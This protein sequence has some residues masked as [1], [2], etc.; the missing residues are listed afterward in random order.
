MIFRK[1]RNSE[2]YFPLPNCIFNL[3]LSAGEI[4]MYS[5][6]MCCENRKTYQCHPSYSII[7]N[8]I[9]L[10]KNTVKKYVDMLVKK[11]LICTEQTTIKLKSGAIHNGNLLYTIRPIQDAVDYYDKQ[12][13]LQLQIESARIRAQKAIEGYDQKHRKDVI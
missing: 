3:G 1:Q 7:G 13:M 12:Q 9:G 6:L 2:K 8:A 11:E 4:S 10:S 5:Y